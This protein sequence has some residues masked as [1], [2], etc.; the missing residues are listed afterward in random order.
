[1]LKY[2]L[3]PRGPYNSAPLPTLLYF[4]VES[5][6]QIKFQLSS[7]K[8]AEKD[9]GDVSAD[10]DNPLPLNIHVAKF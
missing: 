9:R 10:P 8:T 4:D 6:W 2:C 3:Q 7:F 1:M 5:V